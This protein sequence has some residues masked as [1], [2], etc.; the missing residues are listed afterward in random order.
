MTIVTG[1][2][3]TRADLAGREAATWFIRKP[4]EYK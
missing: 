4:I 3:V 2:T 1:Q